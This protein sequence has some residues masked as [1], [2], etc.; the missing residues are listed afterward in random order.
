MINIVPIVEGHGEANGLPNLL[1]NILFNHFSRYDVEIDRPV[2]AKGRQDLELR[3][4]THIGRATDRDTCDGILILV[5][6]DVDCPVKVANTLR[7]EVR[8][9]GVSVP[10]EIVYAHHSYESWFLASIESIR[11]VAGISETA[12]FDGNPDEIPDPKEWLRRHLRQGIAYKETTH[13]PELSARIDI[14]SAH[15]SSRSFRKLC[16]AVEQLIE[17]IESNTP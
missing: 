15:T 14:V 4:E 16:H 17:E 11:G 5:D 1:R 12:M 6:A 7:C 13:Q 9:L 3:L 2:R 8:K 10:V